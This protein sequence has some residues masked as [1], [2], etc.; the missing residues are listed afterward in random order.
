MQLV[1]DTARPQTT[2]VALPSR[3][4]GTIPVTVRLDPARYDRLK[5]VVRRLSTTGQSI[6]QSLTLNEA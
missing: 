2:A 6:I 4:N 1:E 3:R 5:R